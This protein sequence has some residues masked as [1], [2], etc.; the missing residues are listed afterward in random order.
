MTIHLRPLSL[1][2]PSAAVHAA[3]A[4]PIHLTHQPLPPRSTI[5][6]PPLPPTTP[7]RPRALTPLPV[8]IRLTIHL[9]TLPAQPLS[10]PPHRSTISRRRPHTHTCRRR[11]VSPLCHTA[12]VMRRSSVR[13]ADPSTDA[14]RH[15]HQR[16]VARPSS[17]H[18]RAACT[19]CPSAHTSSH[20]AILILLVL[21]IRP[22]SSPLSDPAVPCR[23]GPPRHAQ[24][25]RS[26]RR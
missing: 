11:C 20:H 21:V 25:V 6:S 17:G 19:F 10:L 3:P 7:S 16:H 18:R 24:P 1:S 2:S 5:L 12:M 4:W 14:H 22:I 9:L 26:A 13:E 23:A 15:H 8:A